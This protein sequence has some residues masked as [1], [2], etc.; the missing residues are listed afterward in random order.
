MMNEQLRRT[1]FS[2]GS[3]NIEFSRINDNEYLQKIHDIFNF[4]NDYKLNE[5]KF[6]ELLSI[7]IR[8]KTP[9]YL[10][11]TTKYSAD[12]MKQTK[13]KTRDTKRKNR[14]SMDQCNEIK[15]K[16]SEDELNMLK[17]E[18]KALTE[19]QP[20]WKKTKK[21]NTEHDKDYEEKRIKRHERYIARKSI[22]EERIHCSFCCVSIQ[23]RYLKK[24][25]TSIKH[26]NCILQ[27]IT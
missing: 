7:F 4:Q 6:K 14:S 21:T 23:K 13:R 24:H 9:I 1:F 2:W 20:L 8:A 5:N 17:N 16:L 10:Y 25:E 26:K 22:N 3:N 27:I 15:S 19:R 18:Y 11:D 12:L